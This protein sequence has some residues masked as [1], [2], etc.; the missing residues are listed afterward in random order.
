MLRSN[1]T[2]ALWLLTCL[3]LSLAAETSSSDE[4]HA[5]SETRPGPVFETDVLPILKAKCLRCHGE[6]RQRA[7]L[8]LS[9]RSTIMKG[10]ESGPPVVPGDL[11]KS[12]L[13]E[14]VH[15]NKMPPSKKDRLSPN[16]VETI[17]RWI[18]TGAAFASAAARVPE[19]TQHDIEPMMLLHCAACHGLR[20]QE[21]GLDLRTKASMLKGGKSGPVIVPG[22]PEAS[23]ILKRIHAGD[24]PPRKKLIEF[25]VK[26]MSD[27]EIDRLTRWIA[28]G[29][30]EVDIEPDIATTEPDPLVT[31]KDRDFWAFRPPVKPVVPTASAN[32]DPVAWQRV[33]NPIDAFILRKLDEKGLSFS[34]EADRLTLLRRASFD[35]TGLPPT[36]KEVQAFLADKDP[37]AYEKM[38]DRLL[39]SPRYGERW[40][41]FWLDLAGYADSE[42]K[43]SADPIRPHAWRYRDYVIRAFND[44]KPYDR[45]LLEQIAGDELV[46]YEKASEITREIMDNLIATGFLRMAPDGT[47][48]D[49]VNY[50]P[51][52]L[53]VVADEIQIFGAAI[54][55]LTL[56]CAR[57]HSHKYDPIP[58]RDYYRLM[59]TFKG[60]YDVY[61]WLKPASVANQTKGN[62]PR[63]ELKIISPEEKRRWQEYVAQTKREIARLKKKLEKNKKRSRPA[64]ANPRT[65][66]GDCC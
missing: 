3:A 9:S 26:P 44:D 28:L 46:D 8:N 23:L 1:A 62:T 32:S 54:L 61:D 42:G 36:P 31:D 19:V 52:R 22:K 24:M 27:D 17:R 34:P 5:G 60:A 21:A 13:W 16:E 25:G 48:S 37:R 59:A 43:R 29:A 15:A 55:G 47:G 58:Q 63:R 49:V 7:E 12:L 40:G 39:A 20:R 45:F 41:R 6:S 53:E 66:D 38:I 2:P 18:A 30:P 14:L 11:E 65:G 35:L 64:I 57:C 51:E 56:Q 10:G 33:R 4:Q 50:V